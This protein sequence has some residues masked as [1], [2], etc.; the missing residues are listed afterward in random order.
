MSHSTK[1]SPHPWPN[2]H[3]DK[4]HPDEPKSVSVLLRRDRR[5]ETGTCG[6]RR[7][8]ERLRAQPTAATARRELAARGRRRRYRAGHGVLPSVNY[9]ITSVGWRNT[10]THQNPGL[11]SSQLDT[12]DSLVHVYTPADATR[13]TAV[14]TVTLSGRDRVNFLNTDKHPGPAFPP[15][16]FREEL[17]DGAAVGPQLSHRGIPDIILASTGDVPARELTATVAALRR[18]HPEDRIRYVHVNDLAVLGSAAHRPYALSE[19]AFARLFG[20]DTPVLMAVPTYVGTVSALLAARGEAHRFHV[21]G[22]QEPGHPVTP[23]GLPK[24][25]GL[26]AATLCARAAQLLKESSS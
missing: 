16:P 14:L 22:Y 4:D 9:L 23:E 1:Y 18:S 19:R 7:R 6:V 21:V 17:T 24:H 10:Y 2:R 13:A 26:S 3:I 5:G 11:A 12:E 20:N 15:D 25:C 8:R